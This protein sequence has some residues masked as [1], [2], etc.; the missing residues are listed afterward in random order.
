MPK[1]FKIGVIAL[2]GA[3]AAGARAG[4]FVTEPGCYRLGGTVRSVNSR[5]VEI[6]FGEA[7]RNAST[8]RIKFDVAPIGLKVGMPVAVAVAVEKAGQIKDGGEYA[9]R[10]DA[11]QLIRADEVRALESQW[12]Y[13]GP[14]KRDGC[15]S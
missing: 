3:M 14:L 6:L 2:L 15:T 7:T 13:R 1:Y 8:F 9:A 5:R 11:L 10:R 4:V 12:S